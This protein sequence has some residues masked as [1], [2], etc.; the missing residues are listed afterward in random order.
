MSD[1]RNVA[2]AKKITQEKKHHPLTPRL[3]MRS[4]HSEER[5]RRL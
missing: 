2:H 5:S 3:T 1:P 4:P